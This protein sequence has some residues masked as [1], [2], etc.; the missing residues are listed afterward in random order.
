MRARALAPQQIASAELRY[1]HLH[2]FNLAGG[3]F[4][5]VSGDTRTY[6]ILGYSDHGSLD[7]NDMPASALAWLESYDSAIQALGAETE[8]TTSTPVITGEPVA[9]LLTTTWY[10]DAPYNGL[11]PVLTVDDQPQAAPTGCVATAMA[12]VMYFH[13]WPREACTEIPAYAFNYD[14]TTNGNFGEDNTAPMEMPA[15]SPVAFDWDNMLLSYK[16]VDATDQQN[17]AVAVLMQ[18]CGQALCMTYNLWGSDATETAI[19]TALRNYFGYDRNVSSAKREYYGIEEWEMLIY[20]ELVAG[21]P[22]PYAANNNV[23]GHSFVCDGFDG[24]GLFHINWGWAGKAD[25]YFRL[26]VLNPKEVES[27]GSNSSPYGYNMMQEAVI[28]VQ[29]PVESAEPVTDDHYFTLYTPMNVGGGQVTINIMYESLSEPSGDVV[30]GLATVV[31]DQITPMFVSESAAMDK[32][33]PVEF[34]V[35]VDPAQ[36]PQGDTRLYP[37]AR[38]AEANDAAWQFVANRSK[39]ILATLTPETLTLRVLPEI[40]LNVADAYFENPDQQCGTEGNIFIKLETLAG[41]FSDAVDI[42]LLPIGTNAP[43]DIN[44][45]AHLLLPSFQTGVFLRVGEPEVIAF[46]YTPVIPG[47]VLAVVCSKNSRE[48]LAYNVATVGGDVPYW[49]FE[50]ENYSFD[51][52]E[53]AVIGSMTIRNNDERQW[54]FF[55]GLSYLI[56]HIDGNDHLCRGLNTYGQGESQNMF[57]DFNVYEEDLGEEPQA[58]YTI[59][60]SQVLGESYV[61][62]FWTMEIEPGGEYNGV[63]AVSADHPEAAPE[64]YNLQGIRVATPVAGQI[65]I[66]RTATTATTIRF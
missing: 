23:S 56:I 25:G 4:V 36:L 12:Q 20:N 30:V 18:Y 22:V 9:P 47:N 60:A 21:R 52:L 8:A 45:P 34:H 38:K 40:K 42:Y 5:V 10:Q 48:I 58:S 50:V 61:K 33:T 1:H 46:S 14:K 51:F 17:Q 11:C 44:I 35:K 32:G 65:Y 53:G 43:E 63:E 6:P 62:D 26:S 39:Y 19:T 29:P 24:Q 59:R 3:G 66:R 28:G 7:C 64:W 41:E 2:G 13:Q 54:A 37:V 49:D 57:F 55:D 27:I 15:L 16:D 31:D